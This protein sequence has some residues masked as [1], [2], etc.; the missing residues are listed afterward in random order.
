MTKWRILANLVVGSQRVQ[1]RDKQ[2]TGLDARDATVARDWTR[3]SPGDLRASVEQLAVPQGDKTCDG[4]S[5]SLA[6]HLQPIVQPNSSAR[7]AAFSSDNGL[8]VANR[9]IK[10]ALATLQ[11]PTP[12]LSGCWGSGGR[13]K[14]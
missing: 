2:H 12:A 14:Q 8:L 4:E 10:Q 13:M 7:R 3:T 5:P 9:P 11:L 1:S 6:E